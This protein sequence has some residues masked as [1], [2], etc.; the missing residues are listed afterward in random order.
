MGK[1]TS[2][3][4]PPMV[5]ELLLKAVAEKGQSGVARETGLTQSAI[6]RYL[7]GIGE[8]TT[9]TLQR[10][11]DYF[12][13]S[14]AELRGEIPLNDEI[15]PTTETLLDTSC[16]VLSGFLNFQGDCPPWLIQSYLDTAKMVLGIPEN[17]DEHFN[18]KLNRAKNLAK[19]LINKL[20]DKYVKNNTSTPTASTTQ[21]NEKPEQSPA[22]P[23]PDSAQTA[24]KEPAK[25][26]PGMEG[27]A[28]SVARHK[29]PGKKR[30]S[31]S[32][33]HPGQATNTT[34]ETKAAKPAKKRN[35]RQ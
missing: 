19:E 30:N 25:K 17:S 27:T 16:V 22:P 6:H 3:S 20:A 14:I 31:G 24:E 9:V 23:A 11:A 35:R 4:T 26:I 29:A 7:K 12:G 32:D 5:T 18:T 28:S 21:H 13:V 8:P 10:L 2:K 33:P 1:T 15:N 34:G